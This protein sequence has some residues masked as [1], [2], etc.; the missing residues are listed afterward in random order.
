MTEARPAEIQRL[1]R[2]V[3]L[4]A[5]YD[6]TRPVSKTEDTTLLL[7]VGTKEMPVELNIEFTKFDP[8]G[9]V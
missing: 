4:G 1:V 3:P 8:V 6:V 5:V 9:A 7:A 2:S